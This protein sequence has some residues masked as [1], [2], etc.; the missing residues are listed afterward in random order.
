MSVL[1]DAGP[2]L[3][4]LAVGQENVLIEAAASA[5]LNLAVPAR[6][7]KEILGVCQGAR[8]RRSPVE[9][10][11][12][13]LRS[14]G[15]I[16][17]LDD[18]LST[19]PFID[20]VTRVSG[21]PAHNRVRTGKSLGEIMVLAHASV[22]AQQGHD[23]YVLIDET[24][25]RARAQRE[26]AWLQASKAPADSPSGTLPRFS[27]TRPGRTVGSSTTS[28]GKPST[29]RC[30]SSTTASPTWELASPDHAQ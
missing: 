7:E 1:L 8:F 29:S 28:P 9:A 4:F 2:S 12:R 5:N 14:A 16:G 10:T 30:V 23:V 3:N 6:V 18:T 21:Q 24:D 17:V 15:R 26:I 19:Q 13:K 20:A 22:L 11:W 25:G 27:S